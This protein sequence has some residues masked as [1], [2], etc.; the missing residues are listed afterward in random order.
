MRGM[1]GVRAGAPSG[2]GPVYGRRGHALAGW[3]AV[4]VWPL[5]GTMGGGDA[6]GLEGSGVR[7]FAGVVG[8]VVWC[9]EPYAL[10]V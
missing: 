3:V 5:A 8:F 7:C 9:L 2:R 6:V 10:M 4:A 1:V